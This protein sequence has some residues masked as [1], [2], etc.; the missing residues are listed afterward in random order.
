MHIRHRVRYE[1]LLMKRLQEQ[2]WECVRSAG[3]R[4]AADV[5]AFRKAPYEVRCIQV[6]SFKKL[7][8]AGTLSH[9][10]TAVQE[11]LEMPPSNSYTRWIY[12][13]P[14]R[15]EW[16]ELCVDKYPKNDRKA[17]RQLIKKNWAFWEPIDKHPQ[18]MV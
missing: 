12:V 14:L 16:L 9:V 1:R 13:K 7:A 15:K 5:I 10:V 2:G 8:N 6:K 11:I 4:G 18:D 3:S 17:I